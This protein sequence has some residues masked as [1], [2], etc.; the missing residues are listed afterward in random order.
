L[1]H[2]R[3]FIPSVQRNKAANLCSLGVG[4]T[5]AYVYHSRKGLKIYLLTTEA[6][7]PT[8]TTLSN[9]SDAIRIEERHTMGSDWAKI[10]PYYID[11]SNEGGVIAAVPLLLFAARQRTLEQ[12]RSYRFPSEN[13]ASEM[14]EGA[15]ITVQVSRIERDPNAR[16]KCIS[17][18]GTRCSVCGFDF[19]HTYGSL[20]SGFIQ[21][22]HL[23]PL[24]A[25]KGKRKVDPETDLRP[26][27]PNCHEMLH[28]ENPP[29]TIEALKTVIEAA[30]QC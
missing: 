30:T 11:F 15:R 4:T 17:L 23:R 29:L 25:A 21:V 16:K 6:D 24:A 28:K 26:V 22:H 3:K 5:F 19:E 18:F 10:T 20:G 2:V 1:N 13:S 9:A 7:G 14:V 27:C 8:L 12:R